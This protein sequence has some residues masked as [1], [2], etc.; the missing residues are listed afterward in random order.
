MLHHGSR[1][2]MALGSTPGFSLSRRPMAKKIECYRG[3]L[4][5]SWVFNFIVTI[6]ALTV[7]KVK[8]AVRA[9]E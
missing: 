6:E 3:D 1:Q 7:A 8:T 5:V 2:N 4:S 9:E